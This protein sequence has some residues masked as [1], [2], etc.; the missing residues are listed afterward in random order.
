[1]SKPFT[2]AKALS[3]EAPTAG[4][5]VAGELD[6]NRD[7]V[8]IDGEPIA[9]AP[10][11]ICCNTGLTDTNGDEIFEGD[12]LMSGRADEKGAALTYFDETRGAFYTSRVETLTEVYQNGDDE[13]RYCDFPSTTVIR[14]LSSSRSKNYTIIGNMLD[15]LAMPAPDDDVTTAEPEPDEDDDDDGEGDII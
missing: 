11:T 4:Q 5:V 1:M 15:A 10:Y 7:A 8:W 14:R 13:I 12:Y 6:R 2:I 9:V 3:I